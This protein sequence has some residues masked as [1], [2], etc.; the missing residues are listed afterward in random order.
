[1]GNFS[2]NFTDLIPNYE[3]ENSE[4]S[5]QGQTIFERYSFG[6]PKPEINSETEIAAEALL[7]LRNSISPFYQV[8][9]VDFEEA[10]LG[11][12]SFTVCHRCVHRKTQQEF[13][14]KIVSKHYNCENEI[15]ILGICK[16]GPNIVELYE[17]YEDEDNK[18]LVFELLRGGELFDRLRQGKLPEEEARLIMGNLASALF[19]IHS[20]KV[21]HR[22]L[23]PE[24][25]LF[26]D[27]DSSQVKIVDFGFAKFNPESHG[28]RTPCYTVPYAA[29]EVVAV[30]IGSKPFYDERCDLWSL[31]LILVSVVQ[32]I[33][34]IQFLFP[35]DLG[36][37][38][39]KS[40]RIQS[41]CLNPGHFFQ[42]FSLLIPYERHRGRHG[43]KPQR[44]AALFMARVYAFL[45]PYT[46]N[47]PRKLTAH[48]FFFL[49]FFI[50]FH[51]FI[52][53]FSIQCC[54]GIFYRRH[55]TI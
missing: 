47:L 2:T 12:G 24:N 33:N 40:P 27:Q 18:Y 25:I 4:V 53:F 38:W 55:W 43:V 26:V 39:T 49:Y 15:R 31:G 35:A 51:N 44:R 50:S 29:P 9:H 6:P 37:F 46:L 19:S 21:V 28:M 14:V 7:S 32:Q 23:K 30:E 52:F 10:M 36:S 11:D 16:G 3:T 22:D 34:P 54:L 13:A 17:V 20:R 42:S 45:F 1:M 41:A 8:Y 48:I 5:K